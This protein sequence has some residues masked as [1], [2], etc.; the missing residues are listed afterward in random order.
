MLVMEICLVFAVPLFFGH[1]IYLV[2]E[3]KLRSLGPT[4]FLAAALVFAFGGSII[5]GLWCFIGR[6]V[7]HGGHGVGATLVIIMFLSILASWI[8]DRGAALRDK[9]DMRSGS[10]EGFDIWF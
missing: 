2:V 10:A 4:L 8:E 1:F 9:S 6:P 3:Q 5:Y 7:S